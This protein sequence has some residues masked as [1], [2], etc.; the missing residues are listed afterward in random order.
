MRP[1]NGTLL[2]NHHIRRAFQAGVALFVCLLVGW[3]TR[4][5]MLSRGLE[6]LQKLS[7]QHMEFYRLSLESLLTRNE[8]LP[9]LVA[10]EEKLGKLLLHSDNVSLQQGANRYLR[11]VQGV[12]DIAAA[13]LMDAD[14]LTLAASNF[15]QPMSFVGNN[16]GCRP[17][18]RDAMRGRLG[19]F[20]GIGMT[21]GQPGY[22]LAAPVKVEGKL[23]GVSAIKVNLDSFEA[24]LLKSGEIVLLTDSSGVIFLASVKQWRYRTLTQLGKD[25]AE[26]L[27]TNRTY[28][29]L[30]LM[31]L[32]TSLKLQD[33][34]SMAKIAL[35]N[36]EAGNYLVRSSKVGHLGW[37]MVLLAN[38]QQQRQ[39]A[40]LAGGA[41]V[42]ASALLFFL[43]IYF[44]LSARRYR[45]RRLGEALLRQAHQELE[46]RI[47]TRT[48]ELVA[49]NM[50]LEEKVEAL[51]ST[52]GILRET[53]DNAVQAGK[54]TVLGQMAAGI[55]HEINQPLTA[56][57]TFTDNAVNLL[58]RGQLLDVREN[59]ALI[60]QM[61][62]RMG[63]IVTEIKTFARKSPAE[64]KNIRIADAINQAV[65]L[66]EQRRRQLNAKINIEPFSED[67]QV[68]ADS[69]RFEQ[70]LVNLLRNGLDAVS[71]SPEKLVTVTV[72]HHAPE[73][74]IIIRDSGPGINEAALSRLF[75]PF[76]TTKKAGRGLGL[77]LAI[78][79]M[80]IADL[81]GR[82]SAGNQNKGGAE[83][84]IVLEE[85]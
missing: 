40:T 69:I 83:F 63:R 23:L 82:L 75:E 67:T 34:I 50:S 5:T 15:G 78:S 54:L 10:Q 18:F 24:A 70:V 48:A 26:Q 42:L 53:R 19:R 45:E 55:T 12:S 27:R 84:T 62:D 56:L 9:Q 85:T 59:L 21:T 33:G 76:F 57:H 20:F 2:S 4:Q 22:F 28:N 58:E 74:H 65:M 44:Q 11:D 71:D 81:G 47:A 39:N 25:A 49:T 14:G 30:S 6:S 7:G 72:A 38:T 43:I 51:K 46:E 66:V 29:N 3:V 68:L 80:I 61:A 73:V 52:E 60:R 13:Y 8:S 41:A 77:G 1:R 64:L 32:E 36:N 16:Y 35:P 37:S 17:Y 31:P 79:R